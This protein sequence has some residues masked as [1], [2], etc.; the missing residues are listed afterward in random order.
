MKVKNLFSHITDKTIIYILF[1]SIFLPFFITAILLIFCVF[2][3]IFKG[4]ILGAFERKDGIWAIVFSVYCFIVALINLNFIGAACTL[5]ILSFIIV[6]KFVRKYITLDILN[7]GFD[8]ACFMATITSLLCVV[9]FVYNQFIL[10]FKGTYRCTL[11]FFNSN[12]L[13]TLFATVIIICGFNVLNH[14]RKPIYY[15]I[16]AVFCAVGAYLTGSMFVWVEVFIGCSA[17][18]FLTR[19]HQLLSALFLLAGTFIIVLYCIP[20]ILP[21]INESNI[22]TDNR[23]I[24]W[25]TTLN[26]IKDSTPIFGKG[27]LTY[28]HIKGDYPGSYNTAHSHS[29]LLEPILSFG[30][31][32][33]IF[34]VT[35][36]SYFY[37]RVTVCRNAQHKYSLSSLILA[38]SFAILVHATTDLTF[39][40]LQTGL[41]YSLI[42]ST[43]GIE[44]RFLKIE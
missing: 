21:R 17:L 8:I 32:G 4:K 40:W 20:G 12:Y 44:E 15:Y 22:T 19:K 35:H 10:S 24:I 2:Y 36:F 43:I 9:D 30:I 13:A 26:A 18:L 42:F 33:T 23:M 5:V 34:I 31:I 14:R 3:I 39:M 1:S 38:V 25:K 28:F 11:Y 7:K 29:I 27:F 41:F 37:K 16:V 6:A